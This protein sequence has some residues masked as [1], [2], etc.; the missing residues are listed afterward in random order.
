MDGIWL[1]H[2]CWVAFHDP[3]YYMDIS[4][5]DKDMKLWKSFV[6][7]NDE[8]ARAQLIARHMPLAKYLASVIYKN[9]TDDD[10]CY[11]DYLQYANMGLIEAIDNFDISRNVPFGS[12]A[13]YRIKGAILNG[14]SKF[15][16][17]RD[18]LAM[19]KRLEKERVESIASSENHT[20]LELVDAAL[21]LA[22]SYILSD[23]AL[24]QNENVY[25]EDLPYQQENLSR[26]NRDIRKMLQL[27]N[28]IERF[29]ITKH[30][31]EHKKFVEIADALKITKG[32]VSQ[33]HKTAIQK[34]RIYVS[35]NSLDD[36]L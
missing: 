7:N 6:Y 21:G 24:I 11:D 23:T 26:L 8:T 5:H 10:V 2:L 35:A 36:V 17:K 1:L 31:F 4:N 15:S 20:F 14:I 9:R 13:S 32:R 34:L 12:Y 3:V 27:L 28:K 30:Y 19:R 33:V 22:I 18:Q 29:V 16:E 25:N